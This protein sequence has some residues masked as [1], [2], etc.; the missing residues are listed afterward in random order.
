MS[1]GPFL[2]PRCGWP[3]LV[4]AAALGVV[5]PAAAQVV[6]NEV[7][8]DN[9]AIVSAGGTTPDYVELYNAGTSAVLLAGWSLTDTP[10]VPEKWTFPA[11]ASI[12]AKG[13]LVIWLDS[14]NGYSGLVTTNFALRASGEEVA[15]FH[16]LALVDSIQFGPQ[17]QDRSLGRHPS[18]AAAW[19]LGRPTPGTANQSVPL[20]VTAPL[21]INELMATNSAGDDWLELHN[22]GSN[23]PVAI[24]GMVL[25]DVQ[26]VS[27][28]AAL[29]PNSF[30][31]SGGF[32]EFSCV[33]AAD[34]GNRLDFKLSSTS[35]ET[36]YLY[37]AD[38]ATLID[39]VT[40]GPQ[41][42]DVSYGRLPDGG[43]NLFLFEPVGRATPGDANDWLPLTNV[44][45]NEVLTHTD[46]PLEDAVELLNLS[47]QDIDLSWWWLSNSRADPLKFRLP[48]GTVIPAHGFKVFFEQVGSSL[49]GFNRS[50]TGDSPDFTFNSAHGDEVVLTAGTAAAAVTGARSARDV[51]A[52]ANGVA[53]A[54][55]V[56]S[57]SGTDL[58][59][60]NR[61]TFGHD[62]PATLAEFRQSTG[63]PNADPRVG[64]LVLS[65]ILH[66][67]PDLIVGGITNDNVLDEFLE[68]TSLSSQPLPLYDP[69]Y[70]TN[71]WHLEG[72]ISFRFPT[73]LTLAPNAILLLVSFDPQADP[74]Q[75]AAFRARY[76]VDSGV[77]VLGPY[78]GRLG[79]DSDNLELDQPDPPQ[80]PPHADAGYVPAI[81]VE[82]VN[83]D[84]IGG[85]STGAAGTGLSLQ[86]RDLPGYGN[87]PTNW[88]AAAP[89]AGTVAPAPAAPAIDS[90][91]ASLVVR[92]GDDAVFSVSAG[93]TA[94]LT[95]QWR[96]E[97]VALAGRTGLT[98]SLTQ[99]QTNQAGNYDVV[100]SNAAGAVTSAVARL[101]VTVPPQ[102]L[103]VQWSAGAGAAIAID[104]GAGPV[105]ELLRSSNLTGWTVITRLTNSVGSGL[106]NDPAAGQAPMRFYRGRIVP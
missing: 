93:G 47:D 78:T 19:T 86:R 33:G 1:C 55:H 25:A 75:L 68:L 103:G 76:G 42:R 35:G 87:D 21:R 82:K 9:T 46:P 90:H 6:L 58:V 36:V 43:T 96:R 89:T 98:L 106:V 84:L 73:N 13:H 83:Y 17:I 100:V 44:V 69:A 52:S 5:P 4:C 3:F 63:L 20:G 65:E 74:A 18:G 62:S 37:D 59:P 56:K 15:L 70:P 67:P 71:T 48:T 57:N 99:V 77:P 81:L 39:R 95:G 12:P 16:N 102:M 31:D 40:F 64:P 41:T 104:T 49:P 14:T 53:L 97:G 105:F 51:L 101:S 27:A 79:N 8:A 26:N 38:R 32:L 11:T 61:R 72:G 66:H 28:A 45:V 88:F 7:C 92:P 23:D 30:I 29:W 60:E 80:L 85:W 94:P 24:G 2:I 10:A 34:R 22:P 91:P 54:R 50:G